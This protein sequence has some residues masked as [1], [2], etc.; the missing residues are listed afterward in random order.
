MDFADD[1]WREYRSNLPILCALMLGHAALSRA[2]RAV[3]ADTSSATVGSLRTGLNLTVSMIFI[4]V[5]HGLHALF[6]LALA[7]GSYF[8]GKSLAGTPLCVPVTWVYGLLLLWVKEYT[9]R[10]FVFGS[11]FGSVGDALDGRHLR[12]MHPWHLTLNLLVLRLISCNLD[13]HWAVKAARG[14]PPPVVLQ[15]HKHSATAA[16]AADKKHD[17]DAVIITGSTAAAAAAAAVDVLSERGRVRTPHPLD[18]YTL[19]TCIAYCFYTPLYLAG[20]I[21]S[22]N[23]F[24]SHMRSPA[25]PSKGHLLQYTERLLLA[26]VLL[27][28]VL[29]VAPTFALARSGLYR[30]LTP[31]GLAVFGYAVLNAMW[32]KFLVSQAS[33][34][35]QYIPSTVVH[36]SVCVASLL[37]FTADTALSSSALIASTVEC[38]QGRTVHC[39]HASN[40]WCQHQ[41]NYTALAALTSRLTHSSA[42]CCVCAV[43]NIT[44]HMEAEQAVGSAGRRVT[45]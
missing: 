42:P 21:L 6:P 17:D 1:Q 30:Q 36:S 5:M 38:L 28:S 43:H 2:V 10:G 11:V 20:P 23:A 27:E 15:Q 16:T 19:H 3:A 4:F 35:M 8:L 44:D 39:L 14:D 29:R 26:V 18:S 45:L 25:V 34:L 40:T 13:L 9:Y 31:G 32:L 22:Y 12:G 37:L 24:V 41:Y 33:I 7:S